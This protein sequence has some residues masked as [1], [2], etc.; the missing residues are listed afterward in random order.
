M[1]YG[2]E[3]KPDNLAQPL[4]ILNNSPHLMPPYQ[5]VD[6]APWISQ[7]R[8]IAENLIK[9]HFEVIKTFYNNNIDNRWNWIQSTRLLEGI[10]EPIGISLSSILAK[11]RGLSSSAP[12][13][14]PSLDIEKFL[15]DALAC[16]VKHLIELFGI[17][18]KLL[19][20]ESLPM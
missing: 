6:V 12:I 10:L 14:Y 5:K 13:P 18:R 2:S 17:F 1:L 19:D 16:I 3:P 11:V 8:T 9:E 20:V 15:A 7:M 4:T